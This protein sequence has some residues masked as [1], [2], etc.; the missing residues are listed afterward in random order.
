MKRFLPFRKL[1]NRLEQSIHTESENASVLRQSTFWAG[2]ISWGLI[3][4]AGFGITWLAIAKTEE[5]VVAPG[6]L[7]PIG[8][9]K[10]VRMP[11]GGVVDQVL[12]KEGQTV[13]KNQPLLKLDSEATQDRRVSLQ[14]RIV[15]KQQQLDL[16]E[17]ELS[18]YLELNTTEQ[19]S[20]NRTLEL[21]TEVLKRLE[22][23]NKEG[24]VGELQYLSQRNK[25]EEIRGRLDQ[26]KVDRLRQKAILD[27][28][29]QALRSE[30][31]ELKSNL[32][33]VRVN[34]RYQAINSPVAGIV[35]EMKPTGS[36]FVAQTSEPV[37]KIVPFDKLEAS[38]EVS[39]GDIGFVSVGKKADI[40]IDSFPATDFGVLT[41]VV[42]QIGSD[43]IP[44]DQLKMDYRFPVQIKLDSQ[45]L[46]LKSGA[47]LPLQ[48]GMSL[49]ANIK[50]RKVTYLQLLLNT[51]KDKT[52]S[53]RQI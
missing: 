38:V 23:L 20:L 12:V 42:R 25:V 43:A 24:G 53:L 49:S 44:P 15:I 31:N 34:I 50:L 37:L 11:V 35:F 46:N 9:V 41:G 52:D 48:V 6:K 16:K 39:S 40:S 8:E 14:R 17:R 1:Q 32:T 22:M 27:Q 30:L 2:A 4:T 51:F 33:E 13:K 28:G 47:Q 7:V 18:K 36:G 26:T 5:V 29:I 45:Q 21:E 19:Q 3:A 10:E